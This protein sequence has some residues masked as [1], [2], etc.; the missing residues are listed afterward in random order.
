VRRALPGEAVERDVGE[1]VPESTASVEVCS[2]VEVVSVRPSV[3]S[4]KELDASPTAS[5]VVSTTSLTAS[6]EVWSGT[7]RAPAQGTTD[8]NAVERSKETSHFMAQPRVDCERLPVL[9]A[10]K[11]IH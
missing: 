2:V 8:A 6:S 9:P 7:L 10:G 5:P 4:P 1:A 3:G 11:R